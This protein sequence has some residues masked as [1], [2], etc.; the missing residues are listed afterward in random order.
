MPLLLV[1]CFLALQPVVDRAMHGRTGAVV[2]LDVAS[3][4][5]LAVHRP[6]LASR[7]LAAPGSTIK[8]FTLLALL[9]SHRA[10]TSTALVCARRLT[11]SGKR[12]DCTHPPT[13][14]PL[15]PAAALAYSCNSFFAS[16][17][18][19]LRAADLA[20]LLVRVGLTSQTG[21]LPDEVAGTLRRIATVDEIRLLA[22]G[23][24]GIEVTPL[25]LASAYRK[26]AQSRK[27]ADPADFGMLTIYEGLEA[28]AVYGTA[29]AAR[30][31]NVSIAGKTGT[32][33]GHAWFAGYAPARDP[34]IVVV[35]FL[36]SGTGGADAAPIARHIFSAMPP[37]TK[38]ARD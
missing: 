1:W 32:G 37:A 30:P 34:R 19:G 16:L 20:A 7:R 6:D 24:A 2:V 8:P 26:L 31:S 13:P 11:V 10:R 28:A 29:R 33:F 4:R 5:V 27:K 38:V 36:E 25:G 23:V 14:L 35:V 22:L 15:D 3:G 18:E 17:S 12:L 21:L 9:Q